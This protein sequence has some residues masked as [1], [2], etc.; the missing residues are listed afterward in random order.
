MRYKSLVDV[1]PKNKF[2]TSLPKVEYKRLM[3]HLEKVSLSRGQ[4][5]HQSNTPPQSVYFI[6]NG[7]AALTL[8]SSEGKEVELSV[9]GPDGI[10]GERAIFKPGMAIIR[11]EM[12]TDGIAYKIDPNIFLKEFKR[13]G[14]LQEKVLNCIEARIEE[15]AQTALC[16]QMHSVEQRLIRFLLILADRLHSKE[17]DITQDLMAEMLGV[18]RSVVTVAAGKL[19]QAGLIEYL[20][21][22]ITIVDSAGLKDR[23]CECYN[24]IKKSAETFCSTT[25]QA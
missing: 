10:V 1:R 8:S 23:V 16:N 4:V 17:I 3:P 20:R 13:A 25:V 21:G 24:I 6:D 15:T 9:V 12:L 18:T 2:L 14:V 22:H 19:R 11:C 7:I 5:L